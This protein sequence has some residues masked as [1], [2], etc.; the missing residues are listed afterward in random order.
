VRQGAGRGGWAGTRAVGWA[1]W[2]AAVDS[3]QQSVAS[4]RGIRPPGITV[5][6]QHTWLA[7]GTRAQL[8]RALP[9]CCRPC[10]QQR[11]GRRGTAAPKLRP[12]R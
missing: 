9:P 3:Q 8:H 4:C 1:V 2:K 11:R 10:R 5:C 6:L 12:P 7:H